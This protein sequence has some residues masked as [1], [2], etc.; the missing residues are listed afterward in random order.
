MSVVTEAFKGDEERKQ[1]F[2]TSTCGAIP[3]EI[4]IELDSLA[5]FMC[6]AGKTHHGA[7]IGGLYEHSKAM[8]QELSNLTNKLGL[9]WERPQSPV[10][11]GF[12]HDICK[13]QQYDIILDHEEKNGY[14]IEWNKKNILPGHGEASIYILQQFEIEHPAFRLTDEEKACIRYHMGAYTNKEEWSS[15]DA[16]IKKYPNIIYT[17]TADMIASKIIGK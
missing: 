5:Y 8:A 10:I 14:H 4:A 7:Y 16:A 9:T 13:V 17:H 11:I 3:V 2:I 15:L 6:P 1:D 12:L